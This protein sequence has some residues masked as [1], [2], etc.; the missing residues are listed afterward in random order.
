VVLEK[1]G[2]DHLD[3]PWNEKKEGSLDW[4]KLAYELPSETGY[5]SK[6]RGKDR[7]DGKTEE[8]VSSYCMT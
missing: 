5:F 1:D 3:R 7:S 6:D 4:S 2:E 8:D